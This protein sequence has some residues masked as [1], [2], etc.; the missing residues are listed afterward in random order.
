MTALV[1][2]ARI[3]FAAATLAFLVVALRGDD[4]APE[5]PPPYAVIPLAGESVGEA[6][7]DS[8][9]TRCLPFWGTV[10]ARPR[11]QIHVALH[12]AS[13]VDE[14]VLGNYAIDQDGEVRWTAPGMP[15]RGLSLTSDELTRI[16]G[17]ATVPCTPPAEPGFGGLWYVIGLGDDAGASV[18]VDTPLGREVEAILNAALARYDRIRLA[19][20]G[21]IELRLGHTRVVGHAVRLPTGKG[22]TTMTYDDRA[23]VDLADRLLARPREDG[24]TVQGTLYVGGHV[25]PVA[26]SEWGSERQPLYWLVRNERLR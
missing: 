7:R 6:A 3:A 16:R 17:L 14:E 1:P 22:Y 21:H 9:Y 23:L 24:A 19:A 18:S 15:E 13:C 25:I 5:P 2:R 4:P 10:M 12:V 8:G 20:L 26:L 11:W